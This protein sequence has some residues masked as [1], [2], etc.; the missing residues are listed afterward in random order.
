MSSP[1]I[2]STNSTIQL[3]NPHGKIHLDAVKINKQKQQQQNNS[4][5]I[6]LK[7]KNKSHIIYKLSCKSHL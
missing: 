5:T 1:L 6:N 4:K 3:Y 7:N 2:Q